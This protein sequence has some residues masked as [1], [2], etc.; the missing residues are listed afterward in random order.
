MARPLVN[1]ELHADKSAASEAGDDGT[2]GESLSDSD[3]ERDAHP[4]SPAWR[5]KP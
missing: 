5:P 4:T 2:D 3:A 1:V